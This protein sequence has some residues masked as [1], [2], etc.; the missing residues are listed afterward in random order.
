M[1]TNE[2][3]PHLQYLIDHILKLPK[4]PS[5]DDHSHEMDVAVVDVVKQAATRFYSHQDKN[6]KK[7]IRRILRMLRAFRRTLEGPFFDVSEV[8]DSMKAMKIHGK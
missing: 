7:A 3:S 2:P 1:S 6:G 5:Q 4:G 8:K